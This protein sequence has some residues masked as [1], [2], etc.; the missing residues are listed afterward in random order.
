MTHHT[1][2]ERAEFEAWLDKC[3]SRQGHIDDEGDFSYDDDWV[4]GAFVGWAE[5]RRAPAA[6]VPQ[7]WKLVPEEST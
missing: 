7:G 4:Q 3:W 5:G 6:P 2:A 1:D